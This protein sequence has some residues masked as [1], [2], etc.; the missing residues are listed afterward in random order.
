MY[1]VRIGT[2]LGMMSGLVVSLFTAKGASKRTFQLIDRAPSVPVSG[3]ETPEKMEG[4]IRFENVSFHYPSRP[5]VAVLK[6]FTL[7]I[8]KN[9]TVA[10]VGQSGAGKSTVLSLIQRFYD[11][12][13]GSILIDDRP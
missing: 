8:P 12:T 1:S 5:D 7:D 4:H 3:G 2:S 10:F 11:V 6:N 9:Q 13:G